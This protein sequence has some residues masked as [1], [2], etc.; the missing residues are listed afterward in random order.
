[1]SGL[2]LS[3]D[4][5]MPKIDDEAFV[6]TTATVI[7]DVEIGA[8]SG[9]WYGVTIR[10]DVNDIRIGSNTNI[11]DGTVVHVTRKA[12]PTRIGNDI[13]IG[14]MA[15]IH[16]ATLEDGCFIGMRA[17]VMDGVTVESG[18]MVAAGALVTPGKVVKSGEV[19]AGSPA[20]KM[21]DM[22]DAEKTM[23]K[24]SPKGYAMLADFYRTDVDV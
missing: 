18:A 6:A 13:T 20:K 23:L 11:Q 4:G 24:E 19:W 16:G 5:I 21:R 17:T 3:F 12:Y 15:L 14:H 7:G 10:G 1:M 8:H 2:I 9:I 22:T